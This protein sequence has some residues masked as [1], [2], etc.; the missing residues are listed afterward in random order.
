MHAYSQDSLRPPDCSLPGSS[1][2][3]VIPARILECGAISS[4]RGIFSIQGSNPQLLELLHWQ[5][6]SLPLSHL[7]SPYMGLQNDTRARS[8]QRP[9]NP[10]C[11]YLKQKLIELQGETDEPTITAGDFNTPLSEINRHTSQK[12]Q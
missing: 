8:P 12:N 2:Q 9:N 1:V 5:A 4:S 7:G 3:G 6:D 11:I 10:Q